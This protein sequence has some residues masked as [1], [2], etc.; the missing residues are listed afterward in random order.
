MGAYASGGRVASVDLSKVAMTLKRS[1]R[2]CSCWFDVL[3]R[4]RHAAGQGQV[5]TWERPDLRKAMDENPARES[6]RGEGQLRSSRPTP[7]VQVE[8]RLRPSV[9][10]AAVATTHDIIASF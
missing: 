10:W 7:E 3:S 6:S 8:P 9:A 1:L 2:E 5:N 4:W